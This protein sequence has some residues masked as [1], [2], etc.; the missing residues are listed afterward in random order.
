MDDAFRYMNTIELRVED[1]FHLRKCPHNCDLY[2]AIGNISE[3]PP[4][5]TELRT[6]HPELP[7]KQPDLNR[8]W[9]VKPIQQ[10]LFQT[11]SDRLSH[12][13][14]LNSGELA[15]GNRSL[16]QP[17]YIVPTYKHLGNVNEQKQRIQ[18][19]NSAQ[20]NSPTK[21][22]PTT[23]TVTILNNVNNLAFSSPDNPQNI[24]ISQKDLN[25]PLRQPQ[26][27]PQPQTTISPQK[28]PKI[29]TPISI[30]L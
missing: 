11:P 10:G 19:L 15:G 13:Q 28:P 5:N 17:V 24:N 14:N 12:L 8:A 16:Q 3:K 21:N 2:K 23:T 30:F 26:P 4:F 9:G 22:K 6:I 27:Q 1:Y 25:S 7:L 20:R 29:E 18:L